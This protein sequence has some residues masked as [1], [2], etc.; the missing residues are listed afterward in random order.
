MIKKVNIILA[1]AFVAVLGIK[2]VKEV[3]VSRAAAANS[4]AAASRQ[5]EA[6][7]DGVSSLAPCV[8][9]GYWSGYSVQDPISNRNG[10][11]LDMVRAI[12]PN[13]TYRQVRGN[14]EEFAEILR[15]DSNA[16]VVG[17]G[18]HPALKGMVAAPTPM[19][20]CPLVLMTLRTNPW[21]YKDASS[22]NGVRIL[23]NEAF[24]D[25]KVLRDLRDRLGKDSPFLRILPASVSKV[26]LAEMVENGKAD[27][28]VTTGMKNS[29]GAMRDGFTSVRIIQRFRQSEPIGN[30]GTFLF[31]SG[32]NP[33][34]VKRIVDDY[35][36]GIRRIAKSGE[37][38]RIL[39]YYG[40]EPTLAK[41]LERPAEATAKGK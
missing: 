27:A 2:G 28:F 33:E 23:A 35:E 34:F 26:E 31:V 7:K 21:H 16:V 8:C 30:E 3:K 14:V 19:M 1:I 17:F 6:V 40:M 38:R 32:K 4:K 12:F 10:V 37:L 39:A 22:L 36:A 24:L 13:A 25:Y 18:E 5:A 20:H 11:L 15:E 9:Y 41:T 29:E